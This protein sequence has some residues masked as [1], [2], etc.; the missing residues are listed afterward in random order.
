MGNSRSKAAKKE[1]EE[2]D[3]DNANTDNAEQ[4]LED[5]KQ[6][7]SEDGDN[8]SELKWTMD[9]GDR[10]K[11]YHAVIEAITNNKS[12]VTLENIETCISDKYR[13]FTMNS[14]RR[15]GIIAKVIA[16]EF[17]RGN[18]TVKSNKHCS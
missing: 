18:I 10:I 4:P 2:A 16:D 1:K 12:L 3:M 9:K 6:P 13:I 7:A 15:R 14:Y 8:K 17:L 5:T 11:F